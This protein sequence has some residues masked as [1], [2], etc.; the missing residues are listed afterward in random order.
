MLN[1][2]LACQVVSELPMSQARDSSLQAARGVRQ[3]DLHSENDTR[4]CAKPSPGQA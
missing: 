1:G 3:I 2:E 4:V